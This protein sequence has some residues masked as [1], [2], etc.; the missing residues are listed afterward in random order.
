MKFDDIV[1]YLKKKGFRRISADGATKWIYVSDDY[2]IQVTIEENVEEL[3]AEDE[4]RI[5]Q[6]LRELGY[7]D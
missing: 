2:K 4:E 6:R 1:K 3:T 7:L 5:K